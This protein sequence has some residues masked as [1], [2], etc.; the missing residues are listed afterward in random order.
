MVS[1][2]PSALVLWCLD[3]GHL[4]RYMVLRQ[5]QAQGM[6]QFLLLASDLFLKA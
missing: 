5:P 4:G 3:G 6:S 1:A 2:E